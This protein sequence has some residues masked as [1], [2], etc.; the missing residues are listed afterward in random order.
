[1]ATGVLVIAVGPA[2]RLVEYVQRMRKVY[3]AEFLLGRTSDTEDIEGS[4]VVLDEAPQPTREQIEAVLPDFTGRIDQVPPAFSAL[5]VEGRRAYDLARQGRSVELKSRPVVVHQ[6]RLLEYAYPR[7]RL[8]I[9]CGSGTYI[10]SLGRD[11]AAAVGSGAVMAGLI[12]TAI[13]GFQV[14]QACRMEELTAETLGERLLPAR[15]AVADL[16]SV[17]VDQDRLQRLQHG[18][19]IENSSPLAGPEIAALDR[20][21][22]LVAILTSRR[23]GTLSP[24]R[25][26]IVAK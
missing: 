23:R 13:G 19:S 9:S 24:V 21:G 25:N 6:L 26:F 17:Q 14:D 5:K 7:L 1:L 8:E 10:R 16:P 15:L 4:V 12:R 3:V 11:L 2:T 18:L 22:N 20:A